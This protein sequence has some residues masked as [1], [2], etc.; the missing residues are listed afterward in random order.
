MNVIV[1][2][3]VSMSQIIKYVCLISDIFVL[4]LLL[5]ITIAIIIIRFSDIYNYVQD[6]YSCKLQT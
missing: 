1:N 5:F 6:F 2:V 3:M 4:F